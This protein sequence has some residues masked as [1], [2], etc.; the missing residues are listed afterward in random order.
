M[1]EKEYIKVVG[2]R[3]HNLK[4]VSV[5]IPRGK[6]TVVTG[7]SG[8]GKS[9]LAFDTVLAECQRRFFYTLSHY[10]RHFLDMG[11]RPKVNKIEGLSPA[12]ALAQNET[13]ASVRATVASLTDIGELLGVLLAKHSTKY[14][15]HHD[16]P[17]EVKKPDVLLE[18][19][20]D[21]HKTRMLAFC[22]PFVRQKKVPLESY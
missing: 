18:E 6:I 20:L 22:I 14:C 10:S 21:K 17:T 5:D 13:Q 12:I 4:N 8:S 16:L 7:V 3:E 2:A 15:P 19:I 11:Q 9:S 1:S